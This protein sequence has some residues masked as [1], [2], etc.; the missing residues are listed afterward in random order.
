MCSCQADLTAGRIG[1]YSDVAVAPDGT[2][3]VSAY[4]ESYGDLVV[5]KVTAPGRIPDTAWEWVD[6][7]PDGPITKPGSPF[8]HGVAEVG[9][10]VGMYTSIAVAADGSPMVSYF[11][12]DTAS[13]KFAIKQ[14]DTWQIHT[15]DTGT[16]VLGETGGQLVGMYSSISLRSDDHRPG[17]AYLAHVA[18]NGGAVHAEVRYVSAQTPVPTAAGD[19]TMWVVDQAPIVEN[20]GDVYPLPQGLGLFV[21]AA[22]LP[23][24][25][26]V[27][28]YYDRSTGD[29]KLSKFEPSTGQFGAPLLL[30]GSASDEGWSPSVAVDATGAIHV[31]YVGASNDDLKYVTV[32]PTGPA[33]APEVVDDGYRVVGQTVD[34]LPKPEFHFV[35]DDATLTMAGTAPTIVYQDA[36]TQELLLATRTTEG[37]WEHESIAGGGEPWPG[38]YGFFA[39]SAISPTGLVMSSWVVDQPAE[40]SWVEVFARTQ[41]Q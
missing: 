15:I 2:I 12:R 18:V 5:A 25:A 20:P 28:T 14:G 38:A 1:P 27:V 10:D 13:L 21:D 22:R 31:A 23:N 34:N 6:G 4:A 33:T 29:L 24:Q 19:W 37:T 16:G 26:P 3:W 11:D 40:E 9:E 39:A 8:R 7:V 32:P 17:I 36:T 30:D 35:G 41:V